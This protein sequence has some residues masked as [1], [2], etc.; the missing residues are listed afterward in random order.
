[1]LKEEKKFN[2]GTV[3][4]GWDVSHC[5]MQEFGHAHEIYAI[6]HVVVWVNVGYWQFYT[7]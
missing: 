3:P 1:M 5:R 6:V 7:A 2:K 4:V